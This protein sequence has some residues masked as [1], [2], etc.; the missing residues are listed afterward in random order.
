MR[1]YEPMT[2][3][4]P[5]ESS[6]VLKILHVVV[7]HHRLEYCNY[8]LWVLVTNLHVLL[9]SD[10]REGTL[11]PQYAPKRS[12]T[13]IQFKPRCDWQDQTRLGKMQVFKLAE[14]K[15]TKNWWY[16]EELTQT[17]KQIKNVNYVFKNYW[18]L[19]PLPPVS[20]CWILQGLLNKESVRKAPCSPPSGAL[21]GVHAALLVDKGASLSQHT[22]DYI[23]WLTRPN[24]IL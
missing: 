3:S 10:C 15:K 7:G 22:D 9:P 17:K 1:I 6:W 24:F 19:V 14:T 20:I 18:H 21:L 2:C 23:I 13:Q 5:A 11:T 4:R 12:E 16:K 8:G